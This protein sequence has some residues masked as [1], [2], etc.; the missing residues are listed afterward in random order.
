[1]GAASSTERL[2]HLTAQGFSVTEARLAL[3]A[4]NGNVEQAE[5]LLQATRTREAA[6]RR[7]SIG[8]KINLILGEQRPWP[9]FFER[10]LWPEHWE[11]RVA[12]NLLYYQANYVIICA[13]V[14]TVSVLLQPG[15]LL[16]AIVVVV[17]GGTAAAWDGDV[18][19][20]GVPQPLTLQQRLGGASL[21]ASWIV[22]SAGYLGPLCRIA[23]LCGGIVAAHAS[24]R[25]RSL[26]ARWAFFKEEMKVD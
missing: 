4:T 21:L 10:F 14:T 11:E 9:E 24:F 19:Q 18:R 16:L 22:N 1:M 12:T 5:Q 7:G 23:T 13:G 2:N 15:L 6:A 3:E 17:G 20:F 8:A 25:A 26:K